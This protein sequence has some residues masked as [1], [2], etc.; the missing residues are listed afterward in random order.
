M[1]LVVSWTPHHTGHALGWLVG[2]LT[3]GTAFPHLVR[4]VG[5]NLDWRAVILASSLLAVLAGAM[6]LRLGDGPHLARRTSGGIS[7]G[8]VLNA[9][10][11]PDFRSSALG[12]FG[13][14]W[15]LYAFWTLVPLLILIAFTGSSMEGPAW[16]AF[17]SFAVIG[18]G[19][20]GCVL[21]GMLSRRFG[22]ARIA[23]AA[24]AT[25][26]TLC[27]LYPWL[28][29]MPPVAVLARLLLW[30]IAVVADSP[31]FSALSAA[32]CPPHLMASA[33]AIQNSI[34]F[35]ITMVAISMATLAFESWGERVVWLL[36]P[37]PMLGLI[38]MARLLRARRA[39]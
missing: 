28:P 34:G 35:F 24:L 30:G 19:A 36:A 25:S 31:Q 39:V 13:H 27:V 10:R 2:M 11:I 8:A 32:A 29:P 1:K 38:G 4:A 9:F 22:S 23:A 15:E 6:V 26:G 21:G 12:Y 18:I 17:G 33:L 3:L 14:R 7:L 37:G 20:L 5:W 16:V